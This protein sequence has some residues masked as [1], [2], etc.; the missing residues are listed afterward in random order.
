M[1]LVDEEYLKA[2]EDRRKQ[3]AKAAALREKALARFREKRAKVRKLEKAEEERAKKAREEIEKANSEALEVH[4]SVAKAAEAERALM[5]D[6]VDRDLIERRD[7]L[8]AQIANLEQLKKEDLILAAQWDLAIKQ[9][10]VRKIKVPVPPR[11][12]DP[13][14]PPTKP[15]HVERPNP[16]RFTGPDSKEHLLAE[17][18]KALLIAEEREAELHRLR[19]KLAKVQAELDTEIA[20]ALRG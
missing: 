2:V 4:A 17:K 10:S 6:Y 8:A 3:L 20:K 9:G 15:E 19:P 1:D 16:R 18:K 5:F 11:I 7:K 13:D 14:N 12:K